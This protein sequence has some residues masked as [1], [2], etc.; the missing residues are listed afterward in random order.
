M[1]NFNL[2]RLNIFRNDEIIMQAGV[3]IYITQS[4]RIKQLKWFATPIE[5]P[6][7]DSPRKYGNG[8][9]QQEEKG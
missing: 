7:Q 9:P 3:G 1:R 8:H 6:K 5:Y 2:A 4:V